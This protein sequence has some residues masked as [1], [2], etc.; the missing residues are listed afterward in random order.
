M[1]KRRKALEKRRYWTAQDDA[2]MREL[3]PH[4]STADVA[5]RINRTVPSV[6]AR[7]DKLDLAKSAEYLASPAACRLRRGDNVGAEFRFKKGQTPQNKGLR[8]PGWGPGRMK[9][10]QF[11]KG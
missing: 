4:L 5:R 2:Q 10:T 7:A 9:E 3:Y 1:T 11:K 6:Y 8:R